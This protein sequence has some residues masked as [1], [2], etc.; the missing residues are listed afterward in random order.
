MLGLSLGIC[1]FM[2][3]YLFIYLFNILFIHILYILLAEWHGTAWNV[4]MWL[5][6]D[7]SKAFLILCIM[8]GWYTCYLSIRNTLITVLLY[9]MFF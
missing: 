5:I 1:L 4:M 7:A 2:F 8:C 6:S 3:I 9:R